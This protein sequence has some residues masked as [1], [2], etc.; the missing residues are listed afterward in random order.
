MVSR[1]GESILKS[2][3]KS[4]RSRYRSPHWLAHP[5]HVCSL[6]SPLSPT[7][8]AGA[9]V[10]GTAFCRKTARGEVRGSALCRLALCCVALALRLCALSGLPC[11]TAHSPLSRAP[12]FHPCFSF[13]LLPRCSLALRRVIERLIAKDGSLMVL[14][15]AAE[16]AESG[17]GDGAASADDSR[18]KKDGRVL[19]V[20]PNFVVKH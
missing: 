19:G 16:S 14:E 1:A 20:H 4:V 6:P 9:G 7:A 8:R 3:F 11:A 12:P 10:S 18:R 15:E 2:D 17:G 5:A 13:Q